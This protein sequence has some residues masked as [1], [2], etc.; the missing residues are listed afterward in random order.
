MLEPPILAS[1]LWSGSY[2]WDRGGAGAPT[3]GF[4]DCTV[5]GQASVHNLEY[6]FYGRP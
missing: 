3:G 2:G 6:K 4:T 1:C 5:I